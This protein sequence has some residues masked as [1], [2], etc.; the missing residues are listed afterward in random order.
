MLRR[1]IS[2]HLKRSLLPP[3]L[4]AFDFPDVDSSCE[5][6]FITT[7]PGQALALLHGDFLNDQAAK[8]AARVTKEVGPDP[9]NQ[10][11]R[12]IRLALDRP[13]TDDEIADGAE[14]ID[15]LTKDRNQKPDDALKYWCLTVFNLNEF[16]YLD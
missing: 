3:L 2:V 4:T 15:K 16:A 14:L 13:A 5:G 9:R 11:A 1:A 8:L 7:Q 10:I 12:A 6:R